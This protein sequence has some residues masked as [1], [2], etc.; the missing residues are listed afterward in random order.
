MRSRLPASDAAKL[1]RARTVNGKELTVAAGG[2]ALKVDKATV[3]KADVD[4]SNGVIHVID[5][6]MLPE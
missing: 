1:T 4:A 3:V 5:A 6:V 2:G